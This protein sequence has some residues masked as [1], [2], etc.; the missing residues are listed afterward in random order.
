MHRWRWPTL[1]LIVSALMVGTASPR[2]AV[3]QP[4]EETKLT[5]VRAAYDILMDQ[6]FRPPDAGELLRAGWDALTREAGRANLPPPPRL[7][8]LPNGREPA[9]AAFGEA[10]A[11]YAAGLPPGV[12]RTS[13][14]FVAADGM[15][16]SL[17]ERHTGFL[18]PA[19][20]RGFLSAL[21]GSQLPVGAGLRYTASAPWAVTA[22]AP[23][24]PA[25]RAGLAPGDLIV[26]VNG[27]D[28]TAAS[29]QEVG[30]ALTGGAD[31]TAV[32]A[33]E[34]AGERLDLSVTYGPYYFPPLASHMLPGEIGY[35]RLDQF[36]Q[37][38]APLPNGTELLP[39]LDRRLDEL[40]A[41]GARALILDLRGNSGGSGFTTTEL[42]GR[43]LPEDALTVVRSD[44]RGHEATGIVSGGMRRRQLPLVV[45]V[46]GGSASASEVS[47]ATLREAD[48]AVL[49]GQ[50]TAG[51][52]ASSLVLPLPEEAGLQVA[53]AEHVTARSR[54][55]IDRA[56][57]P[58]DVEAA[59]TRT[60]EDYR[61]G[62]DPQLDAAVAALP[63]AP[64]PP[65]FRAV[66]TGM[67]PARLRSLL[68]GYM[69]DPAQVPT[70]DRLTRVVRTG[71]RDFNH[72]NQ[73]LNS[74]GLGGRDPVALQRTLRARGWLG[75]H[76]QEYGAELLVPPSVDVV[77]DLYATPAGAAEAVATNDFPDFQEL[78]PIPVQL[79]D[80]TAAYRGAWLNLGGLSLSWRRGNVVFTVGYGDVPGFE[81]PDTL[82]AVAQL[83][84]QAFAE[85]PLTEALPAGRTPAGGGGGW[86]GL[87][88]D[89]PPS[90]FGRAIVPSPGRVAATRLR[91]LSTRPD[92]DS[93]A[94]YGAMT[95]GRD[96]RGRSWRCPDA[97]RPGVSP[98]SAAPHAEKT[99]RGIRGG[100][101]LSG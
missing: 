97:I 83:V 15:A 68:A 92:A 35:L 28:L 8:P 18:P 34:R 89:Y 41:Q 67:A 78:M 81:R 101:R 70:N 66:T 31:T 59:D 76:V 32:I 95:Y 74:F 63:Q 19:A 62:R 21:G 93:A 4:V 84:D 75:S 26:A 47:A 39:D 46:D 72:P 96:C 65:T 87:P 44:Q 23:D 99:T 40:D 7:A 85:N 64:P 61:L 80:Q 60:A 54:S 58:V 98:Q 45:L 16:R 49:V 25:A 12:S 56:G 88:A 94:H 86:P 9:F 24:G 73:W 6:F 51:A 3:A 69:P 30:Q 5:V 11:Q 17:R 10:Y 57:F 13:V 43:F 22:V 27:K 37:S 42:L 90:L 20:Y 14:A 2:P 36:T 79:G 50:R 82:A 33:V 29:R 77:I 55:T 53:V 91:R 52:L 100:Y 48:R 38:G 1:L 71:S